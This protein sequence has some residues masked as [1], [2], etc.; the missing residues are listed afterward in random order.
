MR[1][2]MFCVF[3]TLFMLSYSCQTSP[4]RLEFES[5]YFRVNDDYIDKT[6]QDTLLSIEYAPPKGWIQIDSLTLHALKARMNVSEYRHS[7]YSLRTMYTDSLKKH[8]FIL[9]ELQVPDSL[10]NVKD[11]HQIVDSAIHDKFQNIEIGKGTFLVN[12]VKTIQY[13]MIWPDRIN[14]KLFLFPER[15]RITQIDFAIAQPV[16]QELT[17]QIESSIGSIKGLQENI[18]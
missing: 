15:N 4:D 12:G 2:F 16:S 11:V 10:K 1:N 3:L 7:T 14:Y 8:L 18:Q 5:M 17:E 13:R 9:G 6:V